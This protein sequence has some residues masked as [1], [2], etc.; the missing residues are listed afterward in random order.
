M[1]TIEVVTES[2]KNCSLS[3]TGSDIARS[4]GGFAGHLRKLEIYMNVVTVSGR[5][6]SKRIK[7]WKKFTSLYIILKNPDKKKLFFYVWW[8]QVWQLIYILGVTGRSNL[9]PKLMSRKEIVKDESVSVEI[10]GESV[11]CTKLYLKELLC[12]LGAE[13]QN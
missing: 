11:P 8:C 6:E 10:Y 9:K 7:C 3:D 2:L 13:V 1:S 5:L 4:S 12:Q